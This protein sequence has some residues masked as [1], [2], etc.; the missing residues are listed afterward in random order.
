MDFVRDFVNA[1]ARQLARELMERLGLGSDQAATFLGG[2]TNQLTSVVGADGTGLAALLE[3]P[4]ELSRAVDV[5]WLS[6]NVGI[7]AERGR[8]G[9]AYL[10]PVLL[11]GLRRKALEDTGLRPLVTEAPEPR[12][13]R[14]ARWLRR[15]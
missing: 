12:R 11:E 14:I 10:A 15:A 9:L 5:R 7:D 6:A 2:L 3:P 4:Q 1:N 8:E 13:G